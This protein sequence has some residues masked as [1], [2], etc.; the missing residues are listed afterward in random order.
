MKCLFCYSIRFCRLKRSLTLQITH[1]PRLRICGMASVALSNANKPTCLSFFHLMGVCAT[2]TGLVVC[3]I[4]RISAHCKAVP[5]VFSVFHFL[6]FQKS[7]L[8]FFRSFSHF[9]CSCST[10]L[11]LTLFL[12]HS[13][14]VSYLCRLVC[15]AILIV[16]IIRRI[17][18]ISTSR[19]FQR[20]CFN[21]ISV[22]IV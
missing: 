8:Y 5:F 1:W 18:D 22:T 12:G 10:L 14:H 3:H 21:I 6:S 16:Q 7:G 20:I 17:L 11:L 15:L 4:V 2:C 19:T 9:S 13:S